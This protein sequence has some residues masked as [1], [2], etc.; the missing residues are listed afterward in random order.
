MVNWDI[1][2]SQEAMQN[3]FILLISYVYF[4]ALTYMAEASHPNKRGATSEE[5]A[6]SIAFLASTSAEM[7]NGAF[8]PIDGGT[9]IK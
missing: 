1:Q 3:S 6:E 5:V 8:L 2:I 7:I 4:Q 9:Y